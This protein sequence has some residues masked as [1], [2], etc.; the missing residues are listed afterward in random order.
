[1]AIELATEFQPAVDELFTSESKTALVTNNNFSWTGAHT[2]KI[3]KVGS[4]SMSDYERNAEVLQGNKS[5]YGEI[6]TLEASTEEM[7]LTKDRSFTFAIDK[8]DQ[9]ETKA[10]LEAASAL[11]RQQREKVI[12]ERDAYIYSV[13][14]DKAGIKPA[15]EALT[16]DT[17]YSKII[18]AGVAMDEAEVPQDGRV[19]ILTPTTYAL[20][21]ASSAVFQN[22]DIGTELRKQGVVDRLD[23]LNVVKI[24]SNRLPANFGF[25]IAHP[26][27]TVAPVKLEQYSVHRDPPFI[28]GSLVE[29]RICYGAFVLENKAKAICYQA[30]A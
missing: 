7:T 9:D 5:R 30:T 15:A 8:L 12:P 10:A 22:S 28:S 24:A 13:M 23:G 4:A 29:G 1:M 18:A 21:K 3:Y 25:M 19:L 26:V 20:L 14:C 6:E 11:A 17:I 16:A 2:I 27:A